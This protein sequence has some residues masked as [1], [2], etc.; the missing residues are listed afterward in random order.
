MKNSSKII[1]KP[2]RWDY[3]E[4]RPRR[5]EK[6]VEQQELEQVDFLEAEKSYRSSKTYGDKSEELELRRSVLFT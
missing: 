2:Y 4:K 1:Q 5:R 3:R 6:K